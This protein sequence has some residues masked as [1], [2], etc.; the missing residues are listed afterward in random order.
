MKLT[1]INKELH[2]GSIRV[3]AVSSS[4]VL[5]IGDTKIINSSSIYDTPSE[6]LLVSPLVPLASGSAP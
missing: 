3:T 1:V 6:S 2:V 4:S 5:L